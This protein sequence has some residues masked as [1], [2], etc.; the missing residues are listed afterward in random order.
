MM[1]DSRG[2]SASATIGVGVQASEAYTRWLW[3]P[4]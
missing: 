4:R 1:Q 3:A 2:K